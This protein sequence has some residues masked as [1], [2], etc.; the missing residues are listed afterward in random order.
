MAVDRDV[1]LLAARRGE[2]ENVS[3]QVVRSV[4]VARSLQ[5]PAVL[6]G[7]LGCISWPLL[8]GVTAGVLALASQ[9]STA[10]WHWVI[11]AVVAVGL[12]AIVLL[13]V[14]LGLAVHAKR[15]YY[16]ENYPE[17]KPSGEL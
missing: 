14:M 7:C 4:A 2:N 17:A 10:W 8:I 6:R 13:A 11:A 15:S 5:M 12:A 9:W 16:R 1:V 3:R